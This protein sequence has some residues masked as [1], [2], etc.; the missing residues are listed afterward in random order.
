M[1]WIHRSRKSVE[2]GVG[3]VAGGQ[4]SPRH[5]CRG[6]APGMG[7]RRPRNRTR[8]A[9]PQ[10]TSFCFGLCFGFGCCFGRCR[11]Q[12]CRTPHLMLR[13]RMH[14]AEPACST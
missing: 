9:I 4:I 3:P 13:R 6:Q 10:E 14:S 8:P 11:A 1:A 2:G 12:P 5:G 7:L